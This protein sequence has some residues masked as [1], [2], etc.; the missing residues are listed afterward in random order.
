MIGPSHVLGQLAAG[1]AF[2]VILELW[3]DGWGYELSEPAV[4]TPTGVERLTDL[5]QE[6]TIRR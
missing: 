6:L 5:P 1:M 4:V 2:H 3:M